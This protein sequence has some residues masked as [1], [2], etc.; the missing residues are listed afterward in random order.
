M[1]DF[2]NFT[3]RQ[4]SKI[5]GVHLDTVIYW[6]E[7][8]LIPL[9]RRNKRNVRQYNIQELKEIAKLRGLFELNIKEQI[10]N[11]GFGD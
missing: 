4:A 10:T 7:Q 3:L 6:E 9:P 5:L 8:R 1:S 11:L 2:M